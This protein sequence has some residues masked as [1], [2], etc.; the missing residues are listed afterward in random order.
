M[1]VRKPQR[2]L[3]RQLQRPLTRRLLQVAQA[4]AAA[5]LA[6]AA[7]AQQFVARTQDGAVAGGLVIE[8]SADG[9][10]VARYRWRNNGRGPDTVEHYRLDANGLPLRYSVSGTTTMGSVIDEQFE[11]Q[12]GTV[13][14]RSQVD[15]G[16]M[17]GPAGAAGVLYAAM[18]GSPAVDVIAAEA[19]ARLPD[20]SLPLTPSGRLRQTVLDRITVSAAG[21]RQALQLVAHTGLGLEP[22]YLWL[23]DEAQPRFFAAVAPGYFSLAPDAWQPVLAELG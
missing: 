18:N 5:T 8:T 12:G 7:S 11:R 13:R 2:P 14:W 19:L 1:V 23:T 6:L 17:P 22:N 9:E 20:H 15:Q 16:E 3:A 4:T 21:Q 10:T